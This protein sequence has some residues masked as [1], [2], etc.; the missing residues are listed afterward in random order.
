MAAENPKLNGQVRNQFGLSL[1][2]WARK[3]NLT[4][5]LMKKRKMAKDL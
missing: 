5:P 3:A 2:V 1:N 4:P